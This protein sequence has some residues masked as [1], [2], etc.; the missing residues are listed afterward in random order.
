MDDFDEDFI[1]ISLHKIRKAIQWTGGVQNK[2]SRAETFFKI[3]P[4]RKENTS[5]QQVSQCKK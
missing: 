3:T 5:T 1:S 4:L 2:V